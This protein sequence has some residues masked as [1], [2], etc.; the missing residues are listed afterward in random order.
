MSSTA[1]I[2]GAGLLT[3]ALATAWLF[4]PFGSGTA[5]VTLAVKGSAVAFASEGFSP[6]EQALIAS[7]A[8]RGD[9]PSSRLDALIVQVK[10]WD[11]AAMIEA[12][13]PAP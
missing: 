13:A 12:S 2:S 11:I 3:V 8:E 1:P 7:I 6:N 10:A 4:A 9:V 5:P